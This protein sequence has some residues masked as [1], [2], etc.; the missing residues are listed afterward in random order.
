[1]SMQGYERKMVKAINPASINNTSFTAL[2]ID[3]QGFAA[4]D[5]IFH[6][7]ALDAAMTTLKLQE[8]DDNSSYS[9]VSGGS[10]TAPS[11]T[12]GNKLYG[13]HV[14]LRGRKRYFKIVATAGNGTATVASAVAGLY[15][16]AI[17]PSSATARGFAAELNI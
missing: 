11:A 8:S 3:T 14:D 17:T 10:H 5:V 12:D 16:G 6:L 9:D 1:M 4:M 15:R 2:S 7:G 13:W